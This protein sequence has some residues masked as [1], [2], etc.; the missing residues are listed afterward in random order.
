MRGVPG[1]RGPPPRW[2]KLR[3]FV[4]CTTPLEA[5][6]TPNGCLEKD[7]RGGVVDGLDCRVGVEED[8]FVGG[9]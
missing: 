1:S 7:E 8:A 2:T 6:C 9:V 5:P 3:L 4:I